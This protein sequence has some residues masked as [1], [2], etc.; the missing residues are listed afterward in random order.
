MATEKGVSATSG[1][2]APRDCTHS[3]THMHTAL[4]ELQGYSKYRDRKYIKQIEK[5]VVQVREKL[6]GRKWGMEL[7]Q[8]HY[9]HVCEY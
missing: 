8:T 7:T 4:N 9:M 3:D 5:V 2:G 6:E 1:I